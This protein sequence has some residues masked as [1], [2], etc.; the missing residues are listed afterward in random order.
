MIGQKLFRSLGLSRIKAIACAIGLL[1]LFLAH[2]TALLFR[3]QPAVSLWFPPS[4][5][6]ISLTLWLGPIGALLAGLASVVIAPYWGSEGWL[7]LVGLADAVEPL[8]AWFFYRRLLNGSLT[9]KGLSNAIAFLLSAPLAGCAA[10]AL[11]GVLTLSTLN[12]MPEADLGRVMVHWWLGNALGT[13]TLAPVA[14]LFLTPR[15][16]QWG[17]LQTSKQENIADSEILLPRSRRVEFGILLVVSVYIA[18]LTVQAT[19]SSIFATLQLALLSSV[20]TLWAAA[21]YGRWGGVLVSS[22]TIGVTLLCYLLVYPQAMTLPFFPVDPELLHTHKLSLA[23]QGAIALVVGTAISERLAAQTTLAQEQIRRIEYQAQAEMG[24]R[25]LLLNRRLQNTNQQLQASQEALR[26]RQQEFETLAENSPDIITRFDRELRYTYANQ[27]HKTATG[28]TLTDL[29]GKTLSEV[30]ANDPHLTKWQTNLQTVIRTGQTLTDEFSL[31]SP[32][33]ALHLYQIRFVPEFDQDG[34]VTSVLTV[35]HDIT[36]LKEIESALRHSE[37]LNRTVLENFPN[38][39]VFVFD[40]DLRYVLAEGL[41]LAATGMTQDQLLGKTAEEALPAESYEVLGPIYQRALLGESCHLEVPCCNLIYDIHV[42]PLRNSN[43]DIFAGLAISQDISDRKR[44][45]QA[46]QRSETVLNAFLTSSPIG[47]ALF[48]TEL[49]YL[50]A[51]E[52]LAAINAVPLSQHIGRTFKEVVPALVPQ[53]EAMFR[54]VMETQEPVLNLEFEG[55]IAPG[56]YRHCLS[57]HFPVC[58]PG[59]EVL[60]VGTTV[61]DVSELR[62]IETALRESE[63]SFRTLADTMPQM[64]WI[65]RP[66]GYHEYFNQR[67]YDYTGTKLEQTQGKG[68]QTILHPEDVPRTQAIWQESLQT[69]KH[70]EVEY[71]LRQAS[72]GE[73]RWH[74]S[75]ALPLRNGAGEIT[76]WFGS[77]TDIHD[78]KLVIEERA[79]ALDRERAARQEL[80]RASQMKDE[81]LAIVSHELRSPLNAILGWSRLLRDRKLSPEKTEQALAS[82]ERNAQAQTQ[83][84]EDLLDI[85]RIIRG[86]VRL[87]LRP[88][89]LAPLIQAALDTV[90]PTASTKSIAL[91]SRIDPQAG[92][93]SGDSERLQQVVWNLLSNAVKFTPEGGHIIVRLK[94]FPA[95][96]PSVQITV[97]DTGKGISPDFLPHV[98]DRFRQ[99]DAT[100]TRAH[101]GL[102]LGLAIVRTLV[103]LHGG[104]VQVD[105]P[106]VGQGATFSVKLPLLVETPSTPAVETNW[107]AS[108]DLAYA[109]AGVKVLVVDDEADTREFLV[110]ALEQFGATVLAADSASEALALLQAN[111]PDVLLSDIGMPQE[112]GYSLIRSVRALSPALGGQIPAAAL[113]AYVRSDDR[114]RALTAGFHMHLSKPIE[115]IQLVTVVASLAGRLT[116]MEGGSGEAGYVL[117]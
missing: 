95:P 30:W 75:R 48:D 5:V 3:V 68:W 67:W 45:E 29:V 26:A 101:G 43:G 46:R 73:Y 117:G 4:G 11:V 89:N 2:G 19:Q 99:A 51:N 88:L 104:T 79:Q 20:P 78:Q 8:V 98:F 6:A 91:K 57:N 31:R 35:T 87:T 47:L 10:S 50:Y 54:E 17:W 76:K 42:L 102:G 39:S 65:T 83:L 38:G 16:H 53:F 96:T 34:S 105:S 64:F 60:G 85:S 113:T 21:R 112:D 71:R 59:G 92:L 56:M 49:R 63:Q 97:T 12:Q 61:L 103:E 84:I 18:C 55:D 37:E 58:L 1:A 106:G 15:L 9:I 41:G 27:A 22:F 100:T 24:E 115:P 44:A 90:Q 62:R 66:D 70:Y 93:V 82:I 114:Q 52:A 111:Q 74:L 69:G 25:L 14:L 33:G 86:K 7:R 80:E 77:C 72:N 23:L 108:V 107:M 116:G 81:F 40:T 110:V 28:L 109:L 13:I 94:R 32:D 36:Q